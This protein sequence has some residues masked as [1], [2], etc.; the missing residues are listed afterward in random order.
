MYITIF[1]FQ[2][3]GLRNR[4][5]L[6]VLL[7][8]YYS[9]EEL[10]NFFPLLMFSNQTSSSALQPR[11]PHSAVSIRVT[12]FYIASMAEGSRTGL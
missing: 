6:F 11:S 12:V 9:I 10:R 1:V 8:F 3:H 2:N 7:G 4:V 5:G